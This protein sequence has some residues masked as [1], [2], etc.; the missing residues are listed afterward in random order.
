MNK[1]L[2]VLS[3]VVI[4]TLVQGGLA[5]TDV[6]SILQ[7][8]CCYPDDSC[9]DPLDSADCESQG[10][11]YQGDGTSCDGVVCA[12][13]AQGA[14]CY[15]DSSCA[16]DLTRTECSGQGHTWAMEPPALRLNVAVA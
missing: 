7:G 3:L 5:P 15:P 4:L 12:A 14:C 2:S 9:A 16:D 8:A 13:Q 11:V 10:G 6:W 1:W